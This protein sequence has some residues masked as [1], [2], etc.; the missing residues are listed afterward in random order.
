MAGTSRGCPRANGG[1][2]TVP[3]RE[4]SEAGRDRCQRKTHKQ[5]LQPRVLNYRYRVAESPRTSKAVL[6]TEAACVLKGTRRQTYGLRRPI[7]FSPKPGARRQG[8]RKAGPGFTRCRLSAGHSSCLRHLVL[9]APWGAGSWRVP[10]R[11]LRTEVGS[12]SR[13]GLFTPEA[14]GLKRAGPGPLRPWQVRRGDPVSW[15]PQTQVCTLPMTHPPTTT[16]QA[17]SL[18]MRRG[19]QAAAGHLR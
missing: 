2:D 19:R 18:P 4:L 8:K 11:R 6:L 12:L 10:A 3:A 17:R 15:L 5:T 13:G 1:M 9:S 7:Y 14:Q 16:A